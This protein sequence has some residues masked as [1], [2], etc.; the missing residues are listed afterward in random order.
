MFGGRSGA[1]AEYVCVRKAVAPVPATCHS[2]KAAAVP[3]AAV[4]ALQGLHDHGQIRPGQHVLINRA[5]AGVG[6][7]AMQIAKAFGPGDRRV[8]HAQRGSGARVR[9]RCR[10]RLHPGGLHPQPAALRPA[11]RRR[12]KPVVGGVPER[13]GPQATFGIVGGP[14]TN[15]WM[16][17]LSHVLKGAW[18]HAGRG[19][20]WFSSFGPPAGP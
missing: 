4:T 1:F 18:R 17:Q 12:G 9:R 15:R 11:A 5:S 13:P 10:Y 19:R 16:G 3:I 8:Q 14:K 6:T 7:F 2:S 20:R